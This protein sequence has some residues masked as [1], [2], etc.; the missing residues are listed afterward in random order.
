M[1]AHRVLLNSKA[2]LTNLSCRLKIT[3]VNS[4]KKLYLN[5][6]QFQVLYHFE[7]SDM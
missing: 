3:V 6:T 5:D 2:G 7:F 4:K 1:E